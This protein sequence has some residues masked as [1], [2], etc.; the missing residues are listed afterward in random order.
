[1][2]LEFWAGGGL[3]FGVFEYDL[4]NKAFRL[5]LKILVLGS[6]LRLFDIL[7]QECGW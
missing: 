2:L 6:T 1:M 3:Q 5:D 4:I 7:F